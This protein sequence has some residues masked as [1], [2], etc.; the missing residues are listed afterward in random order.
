MGAYVYIVECADGHY[1]IG[2]TKRSVEERISEHNA[3]TVAGYTKSRRPVHLRFAE[4]FD[5]LEDAIT[6]ERQIKGWSRAK[7][8]ALMRGDLEAL[9]ELARGSSKRVS[10]PHGS[11]SSP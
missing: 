4:H 6:W 5:R 7:K 1:Y 10:R 2:L 9:V 11:T 8:E 3:G